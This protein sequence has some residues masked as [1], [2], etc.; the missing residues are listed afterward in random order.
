MSNPY[1]HPGFVALINDAKSVSSRIDLQSWVANAVQYLNARIEC[2]DLTFSAGMDGPSRQLA[3]KLYELVCPLFPPEILDKIGC[4]VP[5]ELSYRV[6]K[7]HQD[8]RIVADWCNTPSIP[9]EPLSNER[10]AVALSQPAENLFTSLYALLEDIRAG[11]FEVHQRFS[12]GERWDALSV[13]LL[14]AHN[15]RMIQ[16]RKLSD[17]I[18]RW[19]PKCP[20]LIDR[21]ENVLEELDEIVGKVVFWQPA[22]D[23]RGGE[24][25]SEET[26]L[27]LMGLTGR[28]QAAMKKIAAFE[29]YFDG[30]ETPA[31]VR[32][33]EDTSMNSR[34]GNPFLDLI[35]LSGE[36]Q[37]DTWIRWERFKTDSAMVWTPQDNDRYTDRQ[38]LLKRL[39]EEI[40]GWVLK[41]PALRAEV[42]ESLNEVVTGIGT[43]ESM[44]F[45]DIPEAR[46]KALE[47]FQGRKM[48]PLFTDDAG[49]QKAIEQVLN[50]NSK[51]L[52]EALYGM[53]RLSDYFKGSKMGAAPEPEE[54]KPAES[55]SLIATILARKPTL[56][57]AEAHRLAL[58]SKWKRVLQAIEAVERLSINNGESMKQFA[59]RF[60]RTLAD[61]RAVFEQEGFSD[62]LR[63]L[64]GLTDGEQ[65]AIELLR[66]TSEAA[67]ARRLCAINDA[68]RGMYPNECPEVVQLFH[69]L[70]SGG[71]RNRFCSDNLG[72]FERTTGKPA[73][74]VK[75]EAESKSTLPEVPPAHGQAAAA[76]QV[77]MPT[78]ETPAQLPRE[79]A[80]P[81]V[82]TAE[83][84]AVEKAMV[85]FTRD[86]N[87]S[88]R[89]VA[90]Q[91]PC[92]PSLLSRD[93]R[94]KRL[95]QAHAGSVPKGSK[96]KDRDLEA[97]DEEC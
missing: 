44:R 67:A 46:Q 34:T 66:E 40:R 41:Y 53:D 48:P 91:V 4:P 19:L 50:L 61:L 74:A 60:V 25:P 80:T 58:Q 64:R 92:D 7:V 37:S 1:H 52:A 57:A 8:L 56:Q 32:H 63:D 84:T 35:V 42:E 23:E 49:R 24:Q 3:S 87:Q 90:R 18:R 5:E 45:A 20:A 30:I 89:E 16:W 94:F 86:P 88:L 73:D 72:L 93:G 6:G 97:E 43:M 10:R 39:K 65:F 69:F 14:V 76:P 21:A 70:R 83:L 82:V 38:R 27:A 33:T 95:Q 81:A 96:S 28:L 17:A 22:I 11:A 78:R 79:Q 59:P 12:R 75:V 36:A 9:P 55:D 29:H 15:E 54:G 85:I 13:S 26:F 51:A 62:W 68:G 2:G 77:P 47:V 71:L 31:Q